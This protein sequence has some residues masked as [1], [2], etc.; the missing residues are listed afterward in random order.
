MRKLGFKISFFLVIFCFNLVT[1]IAQE[2]K[3]EATPK[4][5]LVDVLVINFDSVAYIGQ[6]IIFTNV[7][8]KKRKRKKTNQEGKFQI[9]LPKGHQYSIK[10]KEV[11]S[12]Y[13]Y[14]KIDIP[15]S[16]DDLLAYSMVLTYRPARSFTLENVFFD[17]GKATLKP[18]SYT[19]IDEL[20]EALLAKLSLKIEIAGHTDNQGNSQSNQELSLRRAKSVRNYLIQKH[21]ITPERIIAKGYGDSMPVVKNDSS[22]NRQKNRRT[23]VKIIEE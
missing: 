11:A 3:L 9:L 13:E 7:A 14:S 10:F 5:A 21:K 6:E 4:A 12:E 20:G 23:E 15:K 1:S 16:G 22:E 18:N 19:A 8:T 17:T 2:E